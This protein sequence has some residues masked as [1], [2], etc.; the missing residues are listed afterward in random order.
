M[1]NRR[2]I[3]KKKEN[4]TEGQIKPKYINKKITTDEG[5]F[6]SKLEY[7]CYLMLKE[8]E[9]QGVISELKR[10]C[11]FELIPSQWETKV[12]TKVLKTKTKVEE[13][14]VC[15]ERSVVYIADFV[16]KDL[17]GNLNV[18]DTKGMPDGKYPIKRK[19]MLYMHHLKIREVR[20]KD[21]NVYINSLH[22]IDKNQEKSLF[23]GIM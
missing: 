23:D 19:L 14:K 2:F 21:L 16:F 3:Y 10:Q 6:D 11:K 13:K 12:V 9:R 1:Y 18:V 7:D 20:R 15:V 4:G 5:T 22:H 17:K 8:L